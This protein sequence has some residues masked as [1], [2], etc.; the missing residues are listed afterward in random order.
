MCGGD[1][2]EPILAKEEA[3]YVECNGCGLVYTN[4]APDEETLKQ[5]AEEWASDHHASHERLQWEKQGALQGILFD[6]RMKIIDRYKRLGRIL[7]V[8]CST[9]NFLEYAASRGWKT[10]GSELASHTAKLARERLPD[11]DIREGSFLDAGFE[12]ASFDVITM[13]D[14]IE[15]LVD[16]AETISGALRL[17][18]QEGLLVIATPNYNSLTRI[19][20]GERW[21]GLIPPRHLFVFTPGTLRNMISGRGGEVIITRT[22]DINPFDLLAV[23]K[24]GKDYGFKARQENISRMKGV[25]ARWPVLSRARNVLNSALSVSGL[26]DVIEMY[27]ER[28]R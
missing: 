3:L 4:P 1:G 13:W 17:L 8:G 12:P 20:L 7:D 6:N 27:A 25:F 23:L 28:R 2:G 10:A 16:P 18:R 14:V 11:G 9:G 24:R 15:H 5:V 22:I 21:E 19:V 26:G